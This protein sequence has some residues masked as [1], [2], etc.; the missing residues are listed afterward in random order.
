[1]HNQGQTVQE[2]VRRYRAIG[3][4]CRQTAAFRPLQRWS[5]LKQAEEWE[6]AAVKELE[7]YFDRS[8]GAVELGLWSLVHA[9]TPSHDLVA[10]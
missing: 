8:T 9:D 2:K 7:G 5:L 3:S 10:A 6:H 1:M 4:L